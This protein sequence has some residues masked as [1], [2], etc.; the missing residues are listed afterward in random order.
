[1]TLRTPTDPP[2][3]FPTDNVIICIVFRDPNYYYFIRVLLK[4]NIYFLIL[5]YVEHLQNEICD[6]LVFCF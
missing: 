6:K 4:Y 1:M 2:P 3:G 5:I